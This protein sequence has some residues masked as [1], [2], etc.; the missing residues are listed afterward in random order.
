MDVA[1]LHSKHGEKHIL[2]KHIIFWLML[3]VSSK[4]LRYAHVV[5][6]V[7]LNKESNSLPTHEALIFSSLLKDRTSS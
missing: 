5:F 7:F 2:A 6:V 3:K 4:L 1:C